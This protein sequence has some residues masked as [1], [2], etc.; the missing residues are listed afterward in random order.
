MLSKKLERAFIKNSVFEV[1]SIFYLNSKIFGLGT[2]KFKNGRF[3]NCPFGI[4][5]FAFSLYM[6]T[7]YFVTQKTTK[8]TFSKVLSSGMYY[9]DHLPVFAMFF[10]IFLNFRKRRNFHL[11]FGKLDKFDEK[12]K[13]KVHK[14]SFSN[15]SF[16]IRLLVEPQHTR[17]FLTLLAFVFLKYFCTV[18]EFCTLKTVNWWEVTRTSF[19]NGM[20]IFNQLPGFALVFIARNRLHLFN[21]FV[22]TLKTNKTDLKQALSLA[23]RIFDIVDLIGQTFGLQMFASVIV[24]WVSG[25]FCSFAGFEVIV[26]G[27]QKYQKTLITLAVYNGLDIIDFYIICWLMSSMK[28]QVQYYF[29]WTAMNI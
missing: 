25:I 5:L 13:N 16:Q 12:V 4:L 18:V 19:C 24:I 28:N 21:E 11:I 2:F 14:Q 22:R 17:H 23:Y 15:S 1:Y 29:K 7:I 27:N 9:V 10:F 6:T 8:F 20:F 3:R 26:I